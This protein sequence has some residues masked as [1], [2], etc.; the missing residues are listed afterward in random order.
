MIATA[1][2]PEWLKVTRIVSGT[3]KPDRG[4]GTVPKG[5]L[6]MVFSD[7]EAALTRSSWARTNKVG[8][9]FCTGVGPYK[10]ALLGLQFGAF[11]CATYDRTD[12][13][14]GTVL[15]QVVSSSSLRVVRKLS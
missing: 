1:L 9:A 3:L 8:K 13:R 7:A 2:G 11:S 14:S 12:R 4:I 5:P 6:A 10:K 15:V